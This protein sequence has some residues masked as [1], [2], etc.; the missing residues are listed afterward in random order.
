MCAGKTLVALDDE[1]MHD[2][3]S[4]MTHPRDF[5][6]F[7]PQERAPEHLNSDRTTRTQ[8]VMQSE[9]F[10]Q[11]RQIFDTLMQQPFH[12][13]TTDGKLRPLPRCGYAAA[14][15]RQRMDSAGTALLAVMRPAIAEKVRFAQ[16]DSLHW[17]RW[18]NMPMAWPV[19][20][21]GL[22]EM[23]EAERHAVMQL[24][25][26]SLSTEGYQQVLDLMLINQFSGELVGREKYLNRYC[27]SVGLFGHPGD[28]RWGW[29]IYGHHLALNFS[30]VGENWVLAPALLAAEPTLI[31]AGSGA[32]IN[33]FQSTEEAALTLMRSLSAEH[34]RAA[35]I[36]P[37][38][39]TA[40]VPPERR[41][42]ADSLHLA[43]AFQDNR[44]IPYEGLCVAA[45]SKIERD[46]LM[47]LIAS[48]HQ[49]W[50]TEPRRQRLKEI[51]GQLEKTW[52]TWMGGYDA[53]SPFYFR[54]HSS[55]VLLEYDC[56]QA[57]FLTNKEPARFHVHTIAR[58]P[59]GGDYGMDLLN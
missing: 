43:G 54:L 11:Q 51:E 20:G 13:I 19:D 24:L 4:A 36:L 55:A 47:Q 7:V 1:R 59:E 39:L 49:L 52:F 44:I 22:E 18:H 48:F 27:Y 29:Q 8:E 35:Q 56:H 31:D 17:R 46:L 14:S 34:Q 23:N 12:G 16:D 37:S 21:I 32:G 26:A 30:L 28:E 25:R 38:I 33:T 42:W 53:W 10:R 40:D 6:P 15:V 58:I 5:R 2:A 57:V 50:P 41:H 3:F 45:F 9:F